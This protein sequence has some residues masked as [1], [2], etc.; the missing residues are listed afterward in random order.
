[1]PLLT[2]ALTLLMTAS[3]AI[4][5]D[6]TA[7]EARAILAELVAADTTNPPGNEAKAVALLAKRLKA[8]NIPF[9]VST[10]AKG[11]DN[12]VAR[13]AGD[14]SAKPLLLLA[15]LDVVGT[16]DQSWATPPHVMTEKDGFLYGRG[17]GDDL[18]M[19][20]VDLAV[21]LALKRA[22]VPLHRDLIVAFTGDEESGGAGI[23]WLIA[24]KKA[25]IDAEV[26]FNEGGGP[27]ISAD[28]KVN[29]LGL[30][31][32]EKTYQDFRLTAPGVT[33]HSSAPLPH[34][35]IDELARALVEIADHPFPEH[36]TPTTEQAFAGRAEFESDEVGDAMSR[37][38]HAKGDL[39]GDA[40]AILRLQPSLEAQLHTTCVPTL[41]SAGTRVNAL[42]SK[43]EANVNC[44]IMPDETVDAIKEKLQ[45]LAGSI[46]QVEKLADFGSSPA[47]PLDGPGPQ[48]VLTAAKSLWPKVKI[49]PIMST[50]ADDSRFL[51]AANIRAYGF[52]PVPMTEADGRRAH[53]IDERIPAA[54]LRTGVELFERLVMA[55]NAP[56]PPAAP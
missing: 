19:A 4:D 26:A 33:G 36:L 50:G 38:A 3:A 21:L 53:G 29:V 42:P 49:V 10:F 20:S 6:A 37:L 17:V 40:L 2:P 11:R 39:P 8:A 9:E 28:G 22:K 48:A 23:R 16:K 54:G 45:E 32:A 52:Q 51:R 13:L 46:V 14:G 12:L 35:A 41:I 27:L 34:N 25:S 47:V 15:H 56:P 55:L 18:S 24:H 31:T 7:K 5:Y 30:Q 1:M 43:A 44:R